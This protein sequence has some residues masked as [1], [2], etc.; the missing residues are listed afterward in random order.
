[1]MS[2]SLSTSY[3]FQFECEVVRHL[4]LGCLCRTLAF[5]SSVHHTQCLF[6]T[7]HL[8]T[9]TFTKKPQLNQAW[10]L[11]KTGDNLRQYSIPSQFW[12][13]VCLMFHPLYL[14]I[15]MIAQIFHDICSSCYF[16]V[17]ECVWWSPL[18]SFHYLSLAC[19]ASRPGQS[20]RCDGY[21]L[22][23]KELE[24]YLKK[25][26]S[27]KGKWKTVTFVTTTVFSC[28]YFEFICLLAKKVKHSL[29]W[30]CDGYIVYLWI[31]CT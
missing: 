13:S 14:F 24:F 21:I 11:Y 29:I 31:L 10:Y 16:S 2:Q 9:L 28:C 7:Q 22:E 17:M 1:M 6:M 8:V 23:G 25:L 19:I 20:G 3:H 12:L 30:Y 18:S 15:V 26:K 27:K 4:P 5:V